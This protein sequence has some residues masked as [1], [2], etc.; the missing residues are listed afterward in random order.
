MLDNNGKLRQ[1]GYSNNFPTEANSKNLFKHFSKLTDS[2]E[3]FN[4]KLLDMPASFTYV[5]SELH[6][7]TCE[8]YTLLLEAVNSGISSEVLIGLYDKK[9]NEFVYDEFKFDNN[10]SVNI[11][12]KNNEFNGQ[13]S[14]KDNFMSNMGLSYTDSAQTR[15]ISA[16][17]E[18]L[19]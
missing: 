17:S 6:T 2:I 7:I 19:G 5:Q 12:N 1:T 8:H 11:G 14:F 9:A 3:I 16:F 13:F 15:E 18:R 4:Y 10:F